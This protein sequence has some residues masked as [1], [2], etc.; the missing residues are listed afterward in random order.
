MNTWLNICV[1]NKVAV[2]Y[3]SM[4]GKIQV[5]VIKASRRLETV[6]RPMMS[7]MGRKVR[8]EQLINTTFNITMYC[9][10]R[11]KVL[12]VLYLVRKLSKQTLILLKK[13]SHVLNECQDRCLVLIIVSLDLH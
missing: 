2:V 3:N 5:N 12:F 10:V 4:S 11:G 1:K 9:F 6:T 7:W 13:T 8:S